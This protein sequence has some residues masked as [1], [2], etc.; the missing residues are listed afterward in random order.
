[1]VEENNTTIKNTQDAL[2]EQLKLLEEVKKNNKKLTPQEI[3]K[4]SIDK[5][6][7]VDKEKLK[8]LT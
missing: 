7:V 2:D 6:G 8:R 1:M 3:Y 4:L 5:E